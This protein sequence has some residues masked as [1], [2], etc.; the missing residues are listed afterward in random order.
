MLSR[1]SDLERRSEEYEQFARTVSKKF[2]PQQIIKIADECRMENRHPAQIKDRVDEA[3]KI[4]NDPKL[5][6]KYNKRHQVPK[7]YPLVSAQSNASKKF[8]VHGEKSLQ[9]HDEPAEARR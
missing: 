2:T 6:Y 8:G 4:F 7:K 5:A 3:M 9:H 1:Q